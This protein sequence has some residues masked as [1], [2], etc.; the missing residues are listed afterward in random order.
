MQNICNIYSAVSIPGGNI[1]ALRYSPEFNLHLNANGTFMYM[2][3]LIKAVR[4]AEETK[5]V[6]E[7]V[8][9]AQTVY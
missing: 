8:R 4:G 3:T 6:I 2:G 5:P 1:V 9:R 7:T